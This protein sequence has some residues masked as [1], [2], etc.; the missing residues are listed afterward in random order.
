MR[1]AKLFQRLFC[2]GEGLGTVECPDDRGISTCRD[3]SNRSEAALGVRLHVNRLERLQKP[4]APETNIVAVIR[5][6][7]WRKIMI[8]QLR[9]NFCGRIHHSLPKLVGLGVVSCL[10]LGDVL[11]GAHLLPPPVY[12]EHQDLSY[13]LTSGG[14]RI[15]IRD[16]S[17]WRQ[18]RRHIIASMEQVMGPLP[19]PKTPV[20]LDVRIEEERTSDGLVALKL[21]YHTDRADQRTFAWLLKPQVENYRTLPAVLCFHPTARA[22]KDVPAG[23]SGTPSRHYALELAKRGFITL[24][25]DYPS[26]GES[27]HDFETD[28]YASGTM[29]AIY[30][31]V[32]AI[33]LLAERPD[34]DSQRIGCIGHSLGGHHGLFTAVFDQ[35][36]KVVVTSCGFTRFHK[37]M[38]GDL[39]GW[40]GP[41]YM[42]RVKTE[43]HLSPEEMP[44]DFAEV[45]AALAPRGVYVVA[46]IEDDNFDVS[47]VRDVIRSATPVFELFGRADCLRVVYPNC[48]H[49]FPESARQT[50]YAFLDEFLRPA[51]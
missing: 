31:A 33:D 9:S 11:F 15:P 29:K 40:S 18:R 30:E 3:I 8:H 43:F 34:V 46:P 16:T 20:P 37:Y 45:V 10:L 47:G 44:F 21:S 27:H 48:G 14:S 17:D 5:C 24:S 19:K 12:P 2:I 50:A 6:G 28:P 26:F 1:R 39:T 4:I 49:D 35:R 13:Y 32:R 42:P 41:V 36:I 22:G 7:A 25:P 38:K 23:L 51:R